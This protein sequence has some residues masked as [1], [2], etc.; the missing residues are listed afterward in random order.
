MYDYFMRNLVYQKFIL[1]TGEKLE[2]ALSKGLGGII[3]FTRDIENEK[4]FQN[5][6]QKIKTK[7][8]ISPFLSIDQEGG[9]VERTENIRPKRLSARYALKKGEAFLKEQSEEISSE[10][11][12]W[13]L[14][15]NFAPCIDVNTNPN[16]PIIGERAFANNPDE[17]INGAKIFIEASRRN[18]IIPCVKHFPGHGDADKDSHLDLPKINLSLEEMEEF[19]IKPFKKA[20]ENNIEM[21]M[22]AHLHC[23]CFDKDTIPTSLSQNAVGYLRK[24]LHYNG[25]VISDDMFMKG[26]QEFGSLEA[27]IMAIKS[28]VDMFIFRDANVEV[29]KLIENLAEIV[30]RNDELRIKIVESSERILKLKKDY[31]IL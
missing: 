13:G 2:E 19:H 5:L 26:V 29:L 17:V 18:R 7:S 20:V 3:F 22:V 4:Q 25:V 12:S 24:T 21:I 1:G 15:L 11:K 23:T 8:L 31:E 14:N 30:E 28:G 9:R 10:L 6:I 16:N 27:C